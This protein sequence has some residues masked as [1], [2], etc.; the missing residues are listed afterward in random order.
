MF[1][2]LTDK[3]NSTFYVGVT[4]DLVRRVWE[5]KNQFVRLTIKKYKILKNKRI[6]SISHN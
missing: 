4:N 2:I 6:P 3:S 5:L 1:I